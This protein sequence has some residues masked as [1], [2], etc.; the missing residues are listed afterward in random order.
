MTAK[1]ALTG[2]T[3]FIGSSILKYLLLAGHTVYLLARNPSKVSHPSDQLKIIH[4]S[5]Q[6]HSAVNQLTKDTSVIIHCAGRVRG[7][8]MDQFDVDNVQTTRFLLDAATKHNRLRHFIYISS[9]AAR[10]PELSNYAKSKKLSEDL[11]KAQPHLAATIIRPPAVYGHNDKELRPLF[12][13]LRRGIMW[14]PGNATNRFSLLHCDDLGQL[15]AQLATQTPF[16]TKIFEPD[17]NN[18]M[19]YRWTDLQTIAATVFDRRIRCFT[20]P[21]AI[22]NGAAQLNMI[23]SYLANS[24]PMLTPGKTRELLHADWV[25]DP[26]KAVAGWQPTIDFSVGLKKLY[27]L[28]N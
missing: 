13:W 14:V 15:V 9:L 1:V 22:L 11:L 2:G 25:S 6:H 17:D 7:R 18:G 21:P 10:N 12:N 3:G 28:D 20:I 5:L 27:S 26:D 16:S 24:S 8:T 19:G 23:F 4:G